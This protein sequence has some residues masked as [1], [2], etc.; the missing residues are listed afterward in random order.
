M[1]TET[2]N[3]SQTRLAS[4]EDFVSLMK[5]IGVEPSAPVKNKR[6]T[7][8]LRHPDTGELVLRAAHEGDNLWSLQFNS[9]MFTN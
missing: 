9:L 3:N 2:I 7:Q 8:Q 5:S 6:V 4:N 1:E